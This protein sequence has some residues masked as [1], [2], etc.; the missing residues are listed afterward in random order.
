[1]SEKSK[2]ETKN[3]VRLIGSGVKTMIELRLK[4]MEQRERLEDKRLDLEERLE[5]RRLALEE[6]KWEWE[7]SGG[8]ERIR[9]DG[10]PLP[11]VQCPKC[12]GFFVTDLTLPTVYC[13]H[14]GVKLERSDELKP[15]AP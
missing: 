11:K 5:N 8:A 2:K 14:C 15:M 9:G 13:L 4:E 6:K 3:Q 12:E 1:M 10:S 7:K